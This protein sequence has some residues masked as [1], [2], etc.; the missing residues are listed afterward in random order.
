MTTI[1]DLTNFSQIRGVLAVSVADL[2]DD[3]LEPLAL[4]D[5]LAD[6]LGTWLEGWE[7]IR[8]GG[9]ESLARALRI[10]AKYRCASVVAVS[11]QNFMFTQMTDGANAA[12]RSDTEGYQALREA[13]EARAQ[14]YKDRILGALEPAEEESYPT[15]FGVVTPSRDPVTEGR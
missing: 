4:E 13:L 1:L 12:Q 6:D 9:D 10:Y 11:G 15:L 3:I 14:Q 8:D 7:G 2:P 5:D